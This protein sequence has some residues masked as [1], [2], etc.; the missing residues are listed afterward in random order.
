MKV[1]ILLYHKLFDDN[2]STEKYAI[3]NKSFDEQM[4]YLSENGFHTVLIDDL[5]NKEGLRHTGQ[6]VVLI[7]FD[8]GNQSDYTIAVP[9]LKKYG[10]VA[11]FFVTVNW[12]GKKGYLKWS[13]IKEI[14]SLGMSVQS[15]SLSHTF[16]SDLSA[17]ELYK[18]VKESKIK[19][20]DKLN[21][22][23]RYFSLPGGFY[24]R[25]ILKVLKDQ[26][27][28]G[29][30]TSAPGL[31]STALKD[32]YM[33]VLNRFLISRKTTLK[34]YISIINCESLIVSMLKA[35]HVLKSLAKTI[36]GSK[37]Y[38]S[39]WSRYVRDLKV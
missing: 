27:Y 19:I 16:I 24:T 2:L 18:E 33:T 23:V 30:C 35:E 29:L 10:H 17:E 25:N 22:K 37:N 36:I 3:S 34:R 6:K 15:H 7:T 38:Y 21:C 31:N 28:E 9:I 14:Q 39:I 4:R 13:E 1:P 32:K 8:D 26:S 12:I 20:E 5:F 11:N